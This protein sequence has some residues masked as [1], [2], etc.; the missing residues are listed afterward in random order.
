M[1]HI[2]EYALVLNGNTDAMI[3]DSYGGTLERKTLSFLLYPR[4]TLFTR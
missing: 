4:H 2:I 1:I 3:I